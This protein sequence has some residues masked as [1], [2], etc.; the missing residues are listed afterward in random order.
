MYSAGLVNFGVSCE[1]GGTSQGPPPSSAICSCSS[2][3]Q[4]Q[5]CEQTP[6]SVCPSTGFSPAN[7]NASTLN[8]CS[9]SEELPPPEACLLTPVAHSL[10]GSLLT[11]S[12]PP[13]APAHLPTMPMCEELHISRTTET[14][15][16]LP[17]VTQ[18]V[19]S[20][21]RLNSGV[22]IFNPCG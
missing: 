3:S 16:Y 18:P 20:P 14:L 13:R 7:P 4:R 22:R 1:P 15:S 17:E 21:P 12:E 19:E 9:V 2:V 10:S 8:S 11:P 6:S 5:S